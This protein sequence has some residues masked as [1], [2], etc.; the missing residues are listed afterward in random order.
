MKA[1]NILRNCCVAM[2]ECHAFLSEDKL[3]PEAAK[4]SQ[5]VHCMALSLNEVL[6]NCANTQP[7]PS[8]WLAC[9][10]TATFTVKG[11]ED[12]E[13]TVAK[14]SLDSLHHRVDTTAFTSANTIEDLN[15][16]QFLSTLKTEIKLAGFRRRKAH[17][18]N[19]QSG[20]K[21]KKNKKKR[22]KL[23]LKYPSL[24]PPDLDIS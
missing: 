9:N 5:M 3:P 4:E 2:E 6:V 19:E 18:S 12:D 15:S 23:S 7:N 1:I 11:H 10:E 22:H 14:A 24:L 13:S 17:K 21:T 20:K 8:Q 16:E